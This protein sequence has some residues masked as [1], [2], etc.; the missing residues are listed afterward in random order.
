MKYS[1]K[2]HRRIYFIVP[3]VLAV[4]VWLAALALSSPFQV[5]G[6]KISAA[7]KFLLILPSYAFS[8]LLYAQYAAKYRY[9]VVLEKG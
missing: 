3:P 4:F 9:Q 5:F 8:F 6:W 7:L 1:F 2:P